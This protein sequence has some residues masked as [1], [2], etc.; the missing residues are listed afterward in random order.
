MCEG[1]KYNGVLITLGSGSI[2]TDA[3][4]EEAPEQVRAKTHA[5]EVLSLIPALRIH[6]RS[7]CRDVTVADDLVQETLLRA[8]ASAKQFRLGTSLEAWLLHILHSCFRLRTLEGRE[9]PFALTSLA[10]RLPSRRKG[11]E[12]R[13]RSRRSQ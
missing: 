3:T 13:K 7:F 2:M 5:E 9:V 1:S 12:K 4:E 11:H 10:L 8:I 6:A